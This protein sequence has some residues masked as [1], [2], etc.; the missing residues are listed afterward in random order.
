MAVHKEHSE[1]LEEKVNT[2]Q[3]NN[4]SLLREK[5]TAKRVNVSKTIFCLPI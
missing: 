4:A 1:D 2:L 3:D 5:E